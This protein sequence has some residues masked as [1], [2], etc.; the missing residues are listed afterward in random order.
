MYIY[1]IYICI[2]ILTYIHIYLHTYIHICVCVRV[3][4]Y[5]YT[6]IHAC[7]PYKFFLVHTQHRGLRTEHGAQDPADVSG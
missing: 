6:Y 1:I 3:C 4:V 7:I 2:Y 5:I